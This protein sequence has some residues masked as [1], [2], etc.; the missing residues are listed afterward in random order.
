MA[1]S[2]AYTVT[3]GVN[4]NNNGSEMY[5]CGLVHNLK[6]LSFFTATVSGLLM[7]STVT[8]NVLILFAISRNYNKSFKAVFFR[9]IFNIALADLFTGLVVDSLCMNYVVKEGL[10]VTLSETEKKLS[11]ITFFVF[12]GVSVIT[13]GLLS[14]ERLWALIRPFNHLKG[15]AIWKSVLVLVASWVISILVSLSYFKVGFIKCL[16]V[17]A[18]TTVILSFVLMILTLIV[19]QRRLSENQR[20]RGRYSIARSDSSLKQTSNSK[21]L[22]VKAGFSQAGERRVTKTF[23]LMLVV[24]LFSY[25]PTCTMIIYMN[26]CVNCNCELIHSMRDLTYL[27]MVA[28]ALLRPINF[29]ARLRVLRRSVKNLLS[30][31][32]RNMQDETPHNTD[33]SLRLR[34]S[35]DKP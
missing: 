24:F 11:H 32:C 30:G 22:S 5:K 19:Y 13:M 4:N 34:N 25:L 20:K 23:L 3:N 9:A 6:A 29:I 27:F 7:I 26:N 10:G 18:C 14:I 1:S 35:H 15:M 28:G 12:S 17:F 16:V 33:V 31:I 2:S 8:L 21:R